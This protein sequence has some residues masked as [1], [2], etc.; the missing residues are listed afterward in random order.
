MT[1]A[2]SCYE[3]KSENHSLQIENIVASGSIADTIDLEMISD[4]L[5]SC[6]LNKSK[7]PGAVYHIEKPKSAA[8]I[9]ASGRIVITGNRNLNDVGICLQTILNNFKEA[10]IICLDMPQVKVTNIVC[11]YNFGK[12]INLNKIMI[13][14]LDHECIE[15]EPEVFPGLVFRISDPKVVFLLFSSGK[16]IITGGKN[17]DDIKTGLTLIREKLSIVFNT[18]E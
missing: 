8:L 13:S 11:S 10:G 3:K 2:K 17:M 9:F 7:F 18:L 16:I 6:K 12:A 15:Y 4:R 5:K 1:D 14:L